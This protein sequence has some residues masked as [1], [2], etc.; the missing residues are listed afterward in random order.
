MIFGVDMDNEEIVYLNSQTGTEA[1]RFAVPGTSD[2]GD[3]DIGLA[4]S[5]A[6]ELYYI[7]SDDSRG[8]VYVLD[9]LDGSVNST[10]ALSATYN[11]NGLGY[12]STAPG[13][14][15]T[16]GCGSLDM[17]R[18]LAAGGGPTFYWGN[19]NV[20]DAIG[21]DDNGIVFAPQLNTGDIVAVNPTVDTTLYVLDV[22]MPGIV[23]MAYDGTNLYA[24]TTAGMLYTLDPTTGE[25]LNTLDLGYTLDALA[26]T[27]EGPALEVEIDIKPA[28][29][30]NSINLKNK[31]GVT[32]VAILSTP[33]F[34]ATNVD[35]ATVL[36]A[37]VA[38]LRW[39]IED[40][41]EILVWDLVLEEFVWIGDGDDDLI[42]HFSSPAL[43]DDN[44]G[45]LTGASTEAI[46]T[47]QL[48]DGTPI[49][50]T[51]SVNI[52]KY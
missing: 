14:L 26:V 17:H 44:G 30:P 33:D 16:S 22:D 6:G 27:T 2:P 48:L 29:M 47:G 7:N 41:D 28:S 43:R 24:S 37:G 23:G 9:P 36:F 50:G 25:V 10:I 34:D 1:G 3:D 21:S 12:E 4:G 13:Y 39:A 51:D 5:Q 42:L 8:T 18:Y 45:D 32:P 52:I 20:Q 49:V 46:L 15:Y 31:K 19:D 11:K 40:V 38:P 35:P